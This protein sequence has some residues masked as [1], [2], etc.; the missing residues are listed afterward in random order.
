VRK[1]PREIDAGGRRIFPKDFMRSFWVVGSS[2]AISGTC[3][4]TNEAKSSISRA[5]YFAQRE[6]KALVAVEWFRHA[7]KTGPC[8]CWSLRGAGRTFAAAAI[9]YPTGP[10]GRVLQG[11]LQGSPGTR[12]AWPA[13]LQLA[14]AFITGQCRP[15]SAQLSSLARWSAVLMQMDKARLGNIVVRA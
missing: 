3:S 15:L 8:P 9:T 13:P 2:A 10:H 4:L 7:S 6:R 12:Q 5:K 11:S 1:T 14:A